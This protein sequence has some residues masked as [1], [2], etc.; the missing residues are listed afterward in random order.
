MET[1]LIFHNDLDGL[2]SAKLIV[3]S[4]YNISDA[5]A[6]DYGKDYSH[7]L[8]QCDSFISV[9]FAE[10]IAGEKTE[11]FVD[12][13]LRSERAS[14]AKNEI[15]KKAPSCVD[16]LIKENLVDKTLITKEVCKHINTVDSADFR[17]KFNDS[18]TP[19]DVIFPD[20]NTELGRY[21]A[22]NDLLRKNRKTNLS[23]LLLM[24]ETF[25]VST[26]LYFIEKNHNML[27][28]KKYMQHK[29]SFFEKFEKN[30]NKYV[31]HFSNVPVLF[32]RYFS[33]IDW[34][35][36]DKN[37]FNYYYSENLYTMLVFEMNNKI[38]VQLQKNPFCINDNNISLYDIIKEQIE[39]PRG[40]ENILNF[41][42]KNINEATT[43]MNNIIQAISKNI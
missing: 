34:K 37:I 39:T 18:F 7:I 31:K 2:Y 43:E 13:H 12:H 4:E 22:L 6:V 14:G 36:Y 41:T 30:V 19:V 27:N 38:H 32:T 28:F 25:D 11:L 1:G 35:G 3:N 10:N 33:Q 29:V 23:I 9:D 21:L 15:I 26:L 8:T 20:I 24:E 42:F 16:I 17:N 5:Y 40:H